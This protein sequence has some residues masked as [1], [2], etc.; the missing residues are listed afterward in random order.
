M[1]TIVSVTKQEIKEEKPLT[2]SD[3]KEDKHRN[4]FVYVSDEIEAKEKLGIVLDDGVLLFQGWIP[5]IDAN[6]IFLTF[7]K[8]KNRKVRFALDVRGVTYQVYAE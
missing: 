7:D 4:K 5:K 6:P 8:Y 3:L 2:L 1:K